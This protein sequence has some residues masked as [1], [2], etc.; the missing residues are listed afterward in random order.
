MIVSY[1]DADRVTVGLAKISL[2]IVCYLI[3]VVLI[4]VE[5]GL[6]IIKLNTVNML[7]SIILGCKQFPSATD[8]LKSTRFD[9]R[10]GKTYR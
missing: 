6:I 9:A 7:L 10:L 8:N 3:N 2:G 1:L 5:L 4:P